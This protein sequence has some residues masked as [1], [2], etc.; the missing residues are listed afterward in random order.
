[1]ARDGVASPWPGCGPL[2]DRAAMTLLFV[3]LVLAVAVTAAWRFAV[4]TWEVETPR[5]AVEAAWYRLNPPRSLSVGALQQR[6]LRAAVGARVI[7]VRGVAL[8]P[9]TF[10]V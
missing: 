4:L 7:S 5:Q 2:W 1:M 8:V 10:E 3:V 9:S 6:I